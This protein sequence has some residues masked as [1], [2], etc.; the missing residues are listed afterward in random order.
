MNQDERG[1]GA[2]DEQNAGRPTSDVPSEQPADDPR[3]ADEVRR[4]LG[5]GD[6]DDPPPDEGD[7]PLAH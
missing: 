3:G 1:G 4:E 5:P 2:E 6:G 7:E